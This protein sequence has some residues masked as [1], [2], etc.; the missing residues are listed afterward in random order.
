VPPAPEVYQ[1]Y[2]IQQ[3]LLG[4]EEIGGLY[5]CYILKDFFPRFSPDS[6]VGLSLFFKKPR[7][8]HGSPTAAI[9]RATSFI[10][11]LHK[12][13]PHDIVHKLFRLSELYS[14][15]IEYQPLHWRGRDHADPGDAGEGSKEGSSAMGQQRLEEDNTAGQVPGNNTS[16]QA[17]PHG[18]SGHLLTI[19]TGTVEMT[20]SDDDVGRGYV[21]R[22]HTRRPSTGLDPG[23][24]GCNVAKT[25]MILN[26][27]GRCSGRKQQKVEIDV[28]K[29]PTTWGPQSTSAEAMSFFTD[30]YSFS[31]LQE[32]IVIMQVM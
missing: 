3:G 25:R 11:R 29:N 16:K 1:A 22:K 10:G 2:Q 32:L 20:R 28:H 23:S 30:I 31:R 9:V 19:Y 21:T 8:W 18:H 26:N 6:T 4:E 17:S 12:K 7:A 15:D 24:I 14:Q 13:L 27:E 5:N